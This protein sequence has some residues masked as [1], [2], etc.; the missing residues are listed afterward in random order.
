M[1]SSDWIIIPTI[2][3]NKKFHGSSHHQA[4]RDGTFF[5][6][7]HK[8]ITN[9]IVT[10]GI[11]MDNNGKSHWQWFFPIAQFLDES[12]TANPVGRGAEGDRNPRKLLLGLSNK[13]ILSI[14]RGI[15]W[16]S[17]ANK[18]DIMVI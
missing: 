4:D 12:S 9:G 10:N 17:P 5:G 18:W 7:Y 15:E 2:G 3:E 14:K 6:D 8:I 1:S 16:F 11:L 13:Y